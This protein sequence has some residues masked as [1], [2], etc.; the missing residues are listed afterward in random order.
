MFTSVANAPNNPYTNNILLNTGLKDDGYQYL[1]IARMPEKH[2]EENMIASSHI[3]KLTEKGIR[4]KEKHITSQ[5]PT[6]LGYNYT[7]QGSI[8]FNSVVAYIENN[9]GSQETILDWLMRK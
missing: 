7:K 2:F 3:H 5:N 8:K 9:A 6:E 1:A 4:I